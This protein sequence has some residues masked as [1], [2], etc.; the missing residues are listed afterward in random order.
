MHELSSSFSPPRI[1]RPIRTLFIAGP[2]GAGKTTLAD[3]MY[4]QMSPNAFGNHWERIAAWELHTE[5]SKRK[6]ARGKLV[7]GKMTWNRWFERVEMFLF[8]WD[9]ADVLALFTGTFLNEKLR[10]RVLEVAPHSMMIW[11][12]PTPKVALERLRLMFART[13]EAARHPDVYT[14]YTDPKYYRPPTPEDGTLVPGQ[15]MKTTEDRVFILNS[16][17][18]AQQQAELIFQGI[19]GMLDYRV[20]VPSGS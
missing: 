2:G 19:P 16:D 9:R 4:S 1:E 15:L 12:E 11:L 5:A 14:T 7:T 6:I 18:S 20:S 3:T 17:G 10:S 13:S 8:A